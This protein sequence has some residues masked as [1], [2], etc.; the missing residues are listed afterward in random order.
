[1]SDEAVKAQDQ[2][3]M[4]QNKR[5]ITFCGAWTKY[6]FHEDGFTSG[7][8]VATSYLGVKFPF[9]LASPDRALAIN[10]HNGPATHARTVVMNSL[11]LLRRLLAAI[12]CSRRGPT[13]IPTPM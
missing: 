10:L 13:T 1:M 12:M 5:G 3:E 11:E 8:K 2:L 7:L 4:I 9:E 6:G